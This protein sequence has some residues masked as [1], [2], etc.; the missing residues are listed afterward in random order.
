V[1]ELLL[2]AFTAA[3]LRRLFFYTSQR[4]L[5]PVVEELSPNDGLAAMADKAIE[6]CL[7]RDLL[8]T[9]LRE[10]ERANPRRYAT[11]A[12]RLRA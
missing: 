7:A 4:E 3:D 12:S 5:R 6:F 10:V 2:A 8:P 1:R 9:L 11:F